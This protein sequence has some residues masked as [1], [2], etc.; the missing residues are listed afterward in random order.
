MTTQDC[1]ID[2]EMDEQELYLKIKSFIADLD[3]VSI[4]EIQNEYNIGYAEAHKMFDVLANEGLLGVIKNG[5]REV[6]K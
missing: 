1:F 5:R 3:S 4:E 2:L 6:I